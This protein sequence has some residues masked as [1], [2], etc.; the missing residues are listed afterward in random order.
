M[1]LNKEFDAEDSLVMGSY[2]HDLNLYCMT[3]PNSF[4]CGNLVPAAFKGTNG[5]TLI[6]KASGGGSCVV[7][8]CTTA[9][10]AQFQISGTSQISVIKNGS[11]YN[12]DTGI[13]VDVPIANTE[14]IVSDGL[15][16]PSGVGLYQP[17]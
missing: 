11:F 10:G 2:S 8:P 13:E 12:A 15:N 3:S 7:L 16:Q 4:S 14:T 5:I 6:G 9:S 17:N 1:N